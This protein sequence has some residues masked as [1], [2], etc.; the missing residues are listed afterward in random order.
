MVH[1]KCPV[2]IFAS[3]EARKIFCTSCQCGRLDAICPLHDGS[4]VFLQLQI[5]ASD[6]ASGSKG[7]PDWL[8]NSNLKNRSLTVPLAP[9][10]PSSSVVPQF[11]G[12]P[13]SLRKFLSKTGSSHAGPRKSAKLKL[14]PNLRPLFKPGNLIPSDVVPA[15]SANLP[16]IT[17]LPVLSSSP[18][19]SDTLVQLPVYSSCVRKPFIRRGKSLSKFLTPFSRTIYSSNLR[20]SKFT[21]GSK[22]HHLSHQKSNLSKSCFSIA[23]KSTL[24]SLTSLPFSSFSFPKSSLP[25]FSYTPCSPFDELNLV[26]SGNPLLKPIF[27]SFT[28]SSLSSYPSN[29]FPNN[30]FTKPPSFPNL[31]LSPSNLICPCSFYPT[32]SYLLHSDSIR[33]FVPPYIFDGIPLDCISLYNIDSIWPKQILRLHCRGTWNKVCLGKPITTAMTTSKI[34][35]LDTGTVV[36]DEPVNAKAKKLALENFTPCWD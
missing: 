20:K 36:R 15:L 9:I 25:L 12:Q 29:S 35:V 2:A 4:G 10:A 5:P 31:A 14:A 19:S 30:H 17:S 34:D 6:H 32:E 7:I 24:P 18:A 28:S 3:G 22:T 8:S 23:T 21:F 27:E 13:V 16:K 11:L 1:G 26:C 33:P